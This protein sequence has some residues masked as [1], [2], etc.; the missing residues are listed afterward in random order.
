[1]VLD[2][3]MYSSLL[4]QNCKYARSKDKIKALVGYNNRNIRT[5]LIKDIKSVE[6][7]DIIGTAQGGEELCKKIT[8]LKPEIVLIQYNMGDMNGIDV[9]RCIKKESQSVPIFNMIIDDGIAEREID[10]MYEIIG[11]KLNAIVTKENVLRV[12]KE[13]KEF[14]DS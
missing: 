6:Y 4:R 3:D 5:K 13:Y 2:N 11:N 12:L 9:I 7:V 8:T 10:T 1:M 14:I